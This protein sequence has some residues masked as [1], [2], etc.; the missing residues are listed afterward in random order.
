[1]Y[2]DLYVVLISL[3]RNGENF[4]HLHSLSFILEGANGLE[5]AVQVFV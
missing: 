3:C 5:Q 2:N 4:I 1:M